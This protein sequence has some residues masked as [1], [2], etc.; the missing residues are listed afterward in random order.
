MSLIDLRTSVGVG[1]DS[2]SNCT[3][4]DRL[5][6]IDLR[7]ARNLVNKNMVGTVSPRI[8]I[9][10]PKMRGKRKKKKEKKIFIFFH[11]IHHLL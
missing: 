6:L 10:F 1:E 2:E 9:S 3:S 7:E 4:Q 5:V 8:E 11:I